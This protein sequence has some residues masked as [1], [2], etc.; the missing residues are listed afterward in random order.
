MGDHHPITCDTAYSISKPDFVPMSRL[1]SRL[2]GWVD[3]SKEIMSKE[4]SGTV[5][6]R[7]P[8]SSHSATAEPSKFGP[9]SHSVHLHGRELGVFDPPKCD[10]K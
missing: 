2:G 5:R 3:E 8:L 7:V 9:Q 10:E 1:A 6:H 4:T